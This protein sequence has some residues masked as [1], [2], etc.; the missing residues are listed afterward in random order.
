[1]TGFASNAFTF[2]VHIPHQ[3]SHR[4]D[5]HHA[6]T[7]NPHPNPRTLLSFGFE[8]LSIDDNRDIDYYSLNLIAPDQSTTLAADLN[9]AITGGMVRIDAPFA[10]PPDVA[11][12]AETSTNLL[13]WTSSGVQP[14]PSSP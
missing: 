1:M 8:W 7:A 11:L 12:G 5:H 13:N 6:P 3:Q 10:L 4:D 14:L 9:P 2:L